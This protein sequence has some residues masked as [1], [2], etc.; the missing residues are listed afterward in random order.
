MRIC[1]LDGA[2]IY[3]RGRLHDILASSLELPEWYGRNLDALYD[4]LT[5]ADQETEV[6]ILHKDALYENLGGYGPALER[7][8]R[9]AAESNSYFHWRVVD[10]L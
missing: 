8:L 4:C 1:I 6:R 9:Q 5:D 7:V 3:D 2:Q 10:S